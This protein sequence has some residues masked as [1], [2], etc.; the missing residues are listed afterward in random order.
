M[1]ISAVRLLCVLSLWL[2]YVGA[3]YGDGM[4][5]PQQGVRAYPDI[6][7]QEAFIAHRDGVQTLIIQSTIDGEGESFGW[8]VPVPA[9]PTHFEA[10]APGVFDVL[11]QAV[12]PEV[13]MR[14]DA[15]PLWM[16]GGVFF[17]L[18]VS[19]LLGGKNR[20]SLLVF[21]L[22]LALLY[23]MSIPAF[24]K[25]RG[26]ENGGAFG[27]VIER[28]EV[29]GN[30]EVTVLSGESAAPLNQWLAENNY[31]ALPTEAEAIVD[32][33]LREGWRFVATRLRRDG[34]SG[35]VLAP[36]PLRMDFRSE[37]PVYPMRLTALNAGAQGMQL[38][39]FVAANG[40]PQTPP[41]MT[42]EES[43]RLVASKRSVF[44]TSQTTP[45]FKTGHGKTLAL[46][47]LMPLLWEGAQLTRVTGHF[48][49]RAMT[50]DI[51]L[52]IGSA[53]NERAHYF[54]QKAAS[55]WGLGIGVLV[56]GVMFLLIVW[57]AKREGKHGKFAIFIV[58]VATTGG[59]VLAVSILV[60]ALLP[61]VKTSDQLPPK[62]FALDLRIAVS[63]AQQY[64]LEQP[65]VPPAQFMLASYSGK[66]PIEEASPGNYV[67]LEQG[68]ETVIR[69]FDYDGAPIDIR[70]SDF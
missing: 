58:S 36:H 48:D 57:A 55:Q 44:L 21:V 19:I 54:S 67:I 56:G 38:E 10:V 16:A 2:L 15:W 20:L 50:E 3:A 69:F 30:Y 63:L 65:D 8:V 32:D 33:Y 47:D 18:G 41:T 34:P 27:V 42:V 35:D 11:K 45:V 25:V 4:K 39:L 17:I 7:Y 37:A 60:S 66:L 12:A 61:V 9:A 5:I 43:T 24:Q 68:G 70:T 22:L 6:P 52:E 64:M 23:A 13:E 14:A 1:K 62:L 53:H 40:T 29:V 28:Q 46:S 26:Y 51:R 59:A 49:R 31:Q